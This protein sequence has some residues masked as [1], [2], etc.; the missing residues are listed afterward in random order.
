MKLHTPAAFDDGGDVH[1]QPMFHCR[2]QMKF[3]QLQLR[4]GDLK[5]LVN[6][7]VLTFQG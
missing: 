4:L 1:I 2:F 3:V 5:K 6:H 7:Q